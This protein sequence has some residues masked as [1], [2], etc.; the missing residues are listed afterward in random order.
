M[1]PPGS[2]SWSRRVLLE[3]C[4]S[5]GFRQDRLIIH[6]SVLGVEG[7]ILTPRVIFSRGGLDVVVDTRTYVRAYG[8]QRTIVTYHLRARYNN[9]LH[10][11]LS[12]FFSPPSRSPHAAHCPPRRSD[13]QL[14]LRSL[15]LSLPCHSFVTWHVALPHVRRADRERFL[16]R[17]NLISN[18]R[19]STD[20]K[21]STGANRRERPCRRYQELL[22]VIAAECGPRR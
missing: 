13:S 9:S 14:N 7:V 11:Y 22:Q 3:T 19:A 10:H 8:G 15:R 6:Q 2:R 18:L 1:E 16:D 5:P 20:E 17:G 21:T 12:F 4:P